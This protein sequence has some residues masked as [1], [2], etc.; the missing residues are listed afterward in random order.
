MMDEKIK[1]LLVEDNEIAQK[2]ALMIFN[3]HH[4]NVDV[5]DTGAQ[6]LALLRQNNYDVVFLDLGLPDI[7]G[8]EVAK[9]YRETEPKD[10]H[11]LIVALTA[12]GSDA[13]K[14]ACMKAGMDMFIEKPLN[15]EMT[16]KVI[17]RI[18]TSKK[19]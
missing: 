17:E 9:S 12:H 3:A 8:I 16:K 5:A 15:D 18:A 14:E 19:Q 7:S 4:F 1:V 10:C 11:L 13:D 6:S 2:M